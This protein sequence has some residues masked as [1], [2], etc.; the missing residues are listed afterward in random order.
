M[1]YYGRPRRRQMA[2]RRTKRTRRTARRKLTGT[3]SQR[4]SGSVVPYGQLARAMGYA[5]VYQ[6]VKRLARRIT[7]IQVGSKRRRGASGAAVRMPED[8]GTGSYS[9][10]TQDYKS[11][12]F[13]TLTS[14]KIDKMSTDRLIFTHRNIKAFD[15]NG[16]V[17]LQN[18]INAGGVQTF[19][20][21]LF[22]LNSANNIINNVHTLHSPVRYM[23]QTGTQIGFNALNGQ[24]SD[25]TTLAT[26]WQVEQSSHLPGSVGAV[27]LENA[28]HKWSSLDLELWGCK[29]KPTKFHIALVQF[30]EDVLPDWNLKSNQEAEFWQSMVKHYTYNPLAKMDDGF[31]RNKMKIL[32]QYTYNIDPTASFENDAD[33]HVKTVKLYYKFNRMCNF[34]WQFSTPT[35]Q[36]VADMNQADYRTETQQP[37]TQVHP[38]ARIYVMVRASNF[39]QLTSPAP[40]D[41]TTNP[42]I[43][44][45]MRTCYMV[46]N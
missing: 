45:R 12:R 41:N 3:S 18:Y 9:Q 22:E 16:S 1:A 46:N 11:A 5:G 42:S 20:L 34:S 39:T 19:P 4:S 23:Y 13:G 17:F 15:D 24:A 44:W 31:N 26:N 7:P 14:R 27:P 28:I 32:R 43:S 38:N 10:W 37:Q 33:P 30:N 6:G 36:T 25:G 29:N 8:E 35:V 21:M 2:R 40:V